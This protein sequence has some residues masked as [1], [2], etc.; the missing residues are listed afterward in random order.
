MSVR[1]KHRRP[2]RARLPKLALGGLLALTATLGLGPA[3]TAH[4]S[5]SATGSGSGLASTG[6]ITAASALTATQVANTVKVTWAA[7]M[8][9]LGASLTGYYVTRH[10]GATASKACGTDPALPAT[11]LSA[12][13]TTCTDTSVGNGTYTYTVT[14]VLRTWTAQ[15][16]SSNALVVNIDGSAPGLGLGTAA[17]APGA[18]LSGATLWFRSGSAGSVALTLA[19]SDAQSGPGSATFPLVSAPGWTHPAETVSTGTGSAPTITYQSSPITWTASPG[20]PASVNVVGKDVAGNSSSIPVAFAADSAAPTGGALTVNTVAASGA[21]SQSGN[22]TGSFSIGSRIDFAGDVGSGVS[23]S[24]LSAQSAAL[25]NGACGSFGAPTTLVGTPAQSGLAT[26]CY[27]YTLTGTDRVGNASVLSTTVQ[28]DTT[29]PSQSL[30]LAS[31]TGAFLTPGRLFFRGTVAGSFQLA[32]AITD[33]ASGPAQST[34]PV[35]ATTGWTHSAETVSTG[36]GAAPTKTYTSASYTWTAGSAAPGTQNIVGAD[37]AG[38]TV[39]TALAVTRDNTAP[40]GGVLKVNGGTASAAGTTTNSSTGSFAIG[41][42]TEYVEAPSTTAAGLASSVL[43]RETGTLSGTACSGYGPATTLTGSPA[44]SGLAT[45]CYRYTLTGTDNVGNVVAIST[46]V[47]VDVSAPVGGGL[48]VNGQ[49]ASAAVPTTSSSTGAWPIVRTD[50]TDP[51]WT[52]T[53]ST[54]TRQT[55]AISNGVCGAFGAATTILGAPAQTGTSRNCYKYTLTG[56]NT[57]GLVSTVAVI[58]KVDLYVTGVQLTNGSGTAGRVTAGDKIVVTFS[59]TMDPSTFCSA[60]TTSGDQSITGNSQATVTLTNAGT[61][62]T[63]SVT[64]SLCT[65]RL[66]TMSLGSTAYTGATTTFGG[67]GASKSTIAWDAA[68]RTLTVTLGAASGVSP[69]TVATSVV[70]FTPSTVIRNSSGLAIGGVF[71]TADIQQ[72]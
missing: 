72:F 38:N 20:T 50:W 27:R 49:A 62:D 63:M 19:V 47:R 69:A 65:F 64:S 67:T 66:G 16:T 56:T 58:V 28:V 40:A 59:D 2:S 32:A 11:Y 39:I 8:P 70:T 51:Q 43:T 7:G 71:T 29:L 10:A 48:T 22:K 55:A 21:G 35:V 68:A 42:R 26:G 6:A 31:A 46:T 52:T 13:A 54:M 45:G 3:T 25:T 24:V 17:G 4:A 12:A 44:E 18:Y 14:A 61:S 30:S 15:S 37:G 36:S 5:W 23:S 34:F 33:A 60:W 1:P 57:A 9:P 53:T 41:T